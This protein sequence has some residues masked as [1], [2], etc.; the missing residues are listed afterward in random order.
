[1]FIERRVHHSPTA[2]IFDVCN[3]VQLLFHLPRVADGG[4]WH[5][6]ATESED[7]DIRLIGTEENRNLGAKE[8]FSQKLALFKIS[9]LN[10]RAQSKQNSSS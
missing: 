3:A 6:C 10:A 7:K 8:M 9:V 2:W 4:Q 1:M 5:C